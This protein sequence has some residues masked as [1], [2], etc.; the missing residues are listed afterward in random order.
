LR[1][2]KSGLKAPKSLLFLVAL[3]GTCLKHIGV[4]LFYNLD[5]HNQLFHGVA[6]I[7][8]TLYDD[9]GYCPKETFYMQL[10]EI[11]N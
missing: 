11:L 4:S 3:I 2:K 7:D 5:T 8:N 6:T 9:L 1:R 10:K